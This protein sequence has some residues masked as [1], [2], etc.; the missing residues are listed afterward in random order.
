MD[1]YS[2]GDIPTAFLKV[3]EKFAEFLKRNFDFRRNISI[4]SSSVSVRV[5]E[6]RIINGEYILTGNELIKT[7]KFAYADIFMAFSFNLEINN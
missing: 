7:T 5:C 1:L 4:V 2:L 6:S 3:N